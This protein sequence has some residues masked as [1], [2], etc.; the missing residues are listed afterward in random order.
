MT[1]FGRDPA[2]HGR[3]GKAASF[4][5]SAHFERVTAEKADPGSTVASHRREESD[6]DLGVGET[7]FRG[8]FST[9]RLH[10]VE[11]SRCRRSASEA[12]RRGRPRAPFFGKF[13]RA[14]QPQGTLGFTD[15]ARTQ[16]HVHQAGL[17]GNVSA[18][19]TPASEASSRLVPR[20]I[21]SPRR[22]S[23]RG[24]RPSR[25]GSLSISGA[26]RR[27]FERKASCDA[28]DLRRVGRRTAAEMLTSPSAHP[29]STDPRSTAR[30][31]ART[32]KPEIERKRIARAERDF[33][34]G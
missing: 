2:A 20:A 31:E 21:R 11:P 26:T 12:R 7:A 24:R 18:L 5:K 15:D 34:L 1:R 6:L 22:S 33:L 28:R 16:T 25:N 30:D 19:E 13:C 14:R 3:G 23:L 8:G 27:R 9:T 4:C 10:V 29:V 17:G 32:I